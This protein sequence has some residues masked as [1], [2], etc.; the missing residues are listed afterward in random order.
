MAL[1]IIFAREAFGTKRARMLFGS[2]MRC[3][4]ARHVFWIAKALLARRTTVGVHPGLILIMGLS[5]TPT[6]LLVRSHLWNS[7]SAYLRPV[8]EERTLLQVGHTWRLVAPALLDGPALTSTDE[9][10]KS[11]DTVDPDGFLKLE[12]LRFADRTDLVL[13]LGA[14]PWP[15]A[16]PACVSGC[17]LCVV[18]EGYCCIWSLQ[19]HTLGGCDEMGALSTV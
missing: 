17:E 16:F 14:A 1:S 13:D 10:P 8:A 18:V 15:W 3:Q 5:V 2:I 9:E 12:A 7:W 11:S 4:M 6:A 19:D